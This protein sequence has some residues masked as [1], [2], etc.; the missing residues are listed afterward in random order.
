M[1][2]TEI[3]ASQKNSDDFQQFIDVFHIAKTL[4]ISQKL[5]DTAGLA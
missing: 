4:N 3:T 1:L 5:S 2:N